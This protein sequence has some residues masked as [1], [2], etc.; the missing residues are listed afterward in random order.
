MKLIKCTQCGSGD[1]ACTNG[2]LVCRYCGAKYTVEPGDT[3]TEIHPAF[4]RNEEEPGESG[5]DGVEEEQYEDRRAE[6]FVFPLDEDTAEEEDESGENEN[7]F[8]RIMYALYCALGG[9]EALEF[10]AMIA[11]A[12]TLIAA[13]YGIAGNLT[14]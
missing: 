6:V 5:E 13:A 11:V 12:V 8:D 10:I 9:T 2:F 1:L 7:P 14:G 3:G 4:M